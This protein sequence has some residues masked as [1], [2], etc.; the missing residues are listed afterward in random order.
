MVYNYKY[1]FLK[2]TENKGM[3]RMNQ[4]QKMMDLDEK[5][6]MNTFGKRNPVSFTHG[7]GMCLYDTEGKEY[8]DFFAGIA[9]NSLGYHHPALTETIQ[10]QAEKLLHTSSVFYIEQQAQLAKLLVENSCADRVFFG[11]SGAEAN[12][13]AIKLARKYFWKKGEARS[14][15]IT[16]QKSFHGRTLATLSA[17]GQEKYQKPYAPLVEKFIHVPINDIEALRSVAGEKTAAIMLE[18]IQGESGVHPVDP[19][20]L[21]EVRTLCD[22]MGILLIV[23]EVQT[24]VGRTG[25]LFCYEN[26]GI[27]PDIFTLAKGL[28]GGVP[29]GAVCAKEKYCAFEPGDHGTTFG[30]N[31]LSCACG[32]CV[33][34]QMTEHGL[35][36]NAQKVGTYFKNKLKELNSPLIAEVRGM[37]L[38]IGVEMTEAI[39]REVQ[40]KLQ[41]RGILAGAVGDRI[42]RLVPPLIIT[43]KEV[44]IF[45]ENLKAVLAEKGA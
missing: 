27:E 23:D 29:I 40:Q 18:L 20:Y 24:G 35:I 39:G 34:R 22:E 15:F 12:E 21:K 38:M 32:I 14:E 5:Y 4:L 41:Q 6:Y 36:E 42:L 37:G 28:G 7:E 2:D 31:P 13:G 3:G 9:V 25:K 8:L 10:K 44:D 17:T 33:I 19:Q 1:I 43:E 26:Y 11:N 16:L 45:I 30:G